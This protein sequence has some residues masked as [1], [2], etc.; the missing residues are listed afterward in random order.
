MFQGVTRMQRH[1]SFY[2]LMLREG[3]ERQNKDRRY[4][5]RGSMEVSEMDN[6]S[7][8]HKRVLI[9][10]SIFFLSFFMMTVF[11]VVDHRRIVKA[12]I[13]DVQMVFLQN[14][15]KNYISAE[16]RDMEKSFDYLYSFLDFEKV[17]AGR[18][19]EYYR[20]WEEYL[21]LKRDISYIYLGKSE[22]EIYVRPEWIPQKDFYLKKRPWYRKALENPGENNWNLYTDHNDN[23]IQLSI[24]RTIPLGGGVAVMGMDL[25]RDKISNYL[26][27]I[28]ENSN[29][30][31]TFIYSGRSSI[32]GGEKK[33]PSEDFIRIINNSRMKEERGHFKYKEWYVFYDTIN[34]TMWKLVKVLNY[35]EINRELNSHLKMTYIVYFLEILIGIVLII[36]FLRKV[37]HTNFMVKEMIVSAREGIDSI[38][39]KEYPLEYHHIL[40]EI[41]KTSECLNEVRQDAVSDK[42]TCLYNRS[43]FE[44]ESE[45]LRK[46]PLGYKIMFLDLDNFKG[47][48]DTFGHQVGDCVLKRVGEVIRESIGSRERAYRY[49]GEEF[50]VVSFEEEEMVSEMAEKIRSRI[51]KLS[52]REGFISTVSIGVTGSGGGTLE[53]TLARADK[54]LY[55]A[56]AQ[57]K[58]QVRYDFAVR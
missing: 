19:E 36:T 34:P 3:E 57:G 53:E 40:R 58:N 31:E 9:F 54:L 5:I 23:S 24:S 27:N 4:L 10:I 41:E 12:Q 47:I 16:M 33:I 49:G 55:E 38:D 1:V 29:F 32:H 30:E 21:N 51:E 39:F 6:Y 8:F 2:F 22:N 13:I 14:L 11:L 25:G 46:S 26:S 18:V 35:N 15:N 7:S 17:E 50:I 20:L 56:K 45:V 28:I 48:N 42:L 37:K 44:K 43:F 52:W